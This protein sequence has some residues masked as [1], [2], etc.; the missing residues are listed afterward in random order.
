MKHYYR[1]YLIPYSETS[2]EEVK[3]LLQSE[4]EI[5]P[6]DVLERIGYFKCLECYRKDMER[7]VVAWIDGEKHEI[8]VYSEEEPKYLIPATLTFS[9]PI[10]CDICG[11]EITVGEFPTEGKEEELR[12][13]LNKTL[14]RILQRKGDSYREE[15]TSV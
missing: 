11:Q 15:K 3:K 7:K 4:E 10:T 9:E 2:E 6:L 12:L 13:R 8:P 1:G 14:Q 5:D